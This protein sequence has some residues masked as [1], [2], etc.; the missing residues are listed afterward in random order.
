MCNHLLWEKELRTVYLNASFLQHHPNINTKNQYLV[1]N[2]IESQVKRTLISCQVR[3]VF[4][5]KVRENLMVKI[6]SMNLGWFTQ[7]DTSRAAKCDTIMNGITRV[8]N[9]NEGIIYIENDAV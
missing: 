9:P 5:F 1:C 8:W 4:D 6:Q 2:R 3:L 7:I